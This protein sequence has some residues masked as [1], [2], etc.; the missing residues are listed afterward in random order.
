[1][2]HIVTR[3]N[4]GTGEIGLAEANGTAG[5]E[6]IRLDSGRSE[7]LEFLFARETDSLWQLTL[8]ALGSLGA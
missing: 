8:V 3:L 5:Q 7:R 6:Q 1:M 2:R 4:I